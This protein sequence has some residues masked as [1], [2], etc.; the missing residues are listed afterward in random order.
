M[1]PLAVAEE[2]CWAADLPRP[3]PIIN[4]RETVRCAP[5][6]EEEISSRSAGILRPH[7]DDAC[8]AEGDLLSPRARPRA[9]GRV[10]ASSPTLLGPFAPHRVAAADRG[11][12]AKGFEAS[13]CLPLTM[14]FRACTC[15]CDCTAT[16]TPTAV[17]E[18]EMGSRDSAAKAGGRLDPPS[19]LAPCCAGS[20]AAV[21]SRVCDFACRTDARVEL[22]TSRTRPVPTSDAEL[23]L[24]LAVKE[25]ASSRGRPPPLPWSC[26]VAGHLSAVLTR[27][28]R[29]CCLSSSYSRTDTRPRSSSATARSSFTSGS[30][31]SL[32]ALFSWAALRR[33]RPPFEATLLGRRTVDAPSR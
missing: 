23:P 5:A 30:S 1:A 19:T 11:D 2:N 6:V 9:R 12:V 4:S 17:G 13:C 7:P 32:A 14:A 18:H 3:H 31:V 20:T 21:G 10:F 16:V 33:G 28:V 8:A 27:S 26:A 25:Q 24:S 15:M 22:P 29:I